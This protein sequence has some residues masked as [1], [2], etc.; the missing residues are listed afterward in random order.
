M[1]DILA[2]VIAAALDALWDCCDIQGEDVTEMDI[3]KG[4][5]GAYWYII[6]YGHHIFVDNEFHGWAIPSI[7]GV[8]L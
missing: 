6:A 8:A 1:L 3:F 4:A 5:E 7:E 2:R